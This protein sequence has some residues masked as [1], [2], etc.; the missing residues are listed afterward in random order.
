[1]N[2]VYY[3]YGQENDDLS[4]SVTEALANHYGSRELLL[5]AE[6]EL[7]SLSRSRYGLEDWLPLER[8][9]SSLLE[10]LPSTEAEALVVSL[11]A[12]P[13]L[14]ESLKS[15]LR[16]VC[17]ERQW[18]FGRETAPGEVLRL[19]PAGR[20]D[21]QRLRDALSRCA[22]NPR[23]ADR[24]LLQWSTVPEV[25]PEYAFAGILG[26][27][28]LGED[29]P[30]W[31][32]AL[33][34]H[35]D[36]TVTSVRLLAC[37]ALARRGDEA[38]LAEIERCART[39]PSPED[40]GEGDHQQGLALRLLGE[41]DGPRYT[42]LMQ[43]VLAQHFPWEHNGSPEQ[44]AAFVLAQLATPDAVTA[45]LRSYFTAS[46]YLRRRLRVYIPAAVARLEGEDVPLTNQVSIWRYARFPP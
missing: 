41:L 9:Q 37:A 38:R 30:E 18:R 39:L 42:G 20:L 43:A 2:A 36:S 23:D 31:R 34:R 21:D 19:L 7:R 26:L 1:L 28:A 4:G 33:E 15:G 10:C 12:C 11:L 46:D 5:H 35:A 6:A 29:S 32:R 17:W 13:D 14:D 45:L 27:E 44:E 8:W 40:A 24:A 3:G 16:N 25:E 22:S